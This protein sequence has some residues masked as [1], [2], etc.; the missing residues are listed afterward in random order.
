MK[1]LALKIKNIVSLRLECLNYISGDDLGVQG[2]KLMQQF[3]TLV[4]GISDLGS[5]IESL[6]KMNILLD[7]EIANF[8]AIKALN[9][10]PAM[11]EDK[12]VKCQL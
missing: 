9:E 4:N 10:K 3:S 5:A 8:T 2:K 1:K 6:P 7:L 11:S 12:A